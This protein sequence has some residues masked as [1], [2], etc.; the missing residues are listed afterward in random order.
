M[1]V[2]DQACNIVAGGMRPGLKRI[3][4]TSGEARKIDVQVAILDGIMRTWGESL[5]RARFA[6]IQHKKVN[7]LIVPFEDKH[8][9]L[10]I[11]TSMPLQEVERV[12]SLIETTIREL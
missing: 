10:S 3:E 7:M 4:A 1:T 5:G 11:E 2:T 9:E 8:V 12:V 6:L